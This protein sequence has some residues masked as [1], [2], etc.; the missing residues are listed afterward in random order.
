MNVHSLALGSGKSLHYQRDSK[1]IVF[2]SRCHLGNLLCTRS[3]RP[4]AKDSCHHVD[5]SLDG[6]FHYTQTRFHHC[7]NCCT[8]PTYRGARRQVEAQGKTAPHQDTSNSQYVVLCWTS[9]GHLLRD[10]SPTPPLS[11]ST[12][13]FLHKALSVGALQQ[14]HSFHQGKRLSFS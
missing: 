6:R 12:V 8:I 10:M 2:V 13:R 1:P 9:T 4:L 14:H 3:N 7:C 11:M 5:L